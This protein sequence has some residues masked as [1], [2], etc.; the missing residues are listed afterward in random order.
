M[1]QPAN[2]VLGSFDLER[3][4]VWVTGASRGLGHAIAEALLGAGADVAVTARTAGPLDA[5]VARAR[6]SN[7]ALALPASVSDPGQGDLAAQRILHEWGGLDVL[8]NCAGVSPTFKRAEQVQDD[9][10]RAVVDVNLSGTFYCARAAAR[11]MVAGGGGTIVNV[12][13]IHGVAGMPR[14]AAYSASKGGTEALTRTL[15]LEWAEYGIRVNAIS[16]GYFKTEMT[17]GLRGNSRWREQLLDRIPLSRFGEPHELI[18]AVLFLASSA[19]AYVT[20]STL[21]ID[22]GWTA[23]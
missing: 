5:L 6:G 17:E 4:R 19:S 1:T 16:P 3:R 9:E 18:P 10:W 12:S 23:G 8:V 21:V 20:G 2:S 22:G 15:A 7:R 14:L 13:S 11:L